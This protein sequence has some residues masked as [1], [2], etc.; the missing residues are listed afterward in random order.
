[1]LVL[2]AHYTMDVFTGLIVALLVASVAEK[3]S[4]PID[5]FVGKHEKSAA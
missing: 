4:A 5:R 1:M 3:L 2:R